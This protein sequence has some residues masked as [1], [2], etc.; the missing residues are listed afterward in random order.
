M[1]RTRAHS[2]STAGFVRIVGGIHCSRVLRNYFFSFRSRKQKNIIHQP[3]RCEKCIQSSAACNLAILV[4][5]DAP[6]LWKLSPILLWSFF[7]FMQLYG[8][9]HSWY[10]HT[11]AHNIY[12]ILCR[13]AKQCQSSQRQG[14]HT[15]QHYAG[16]R[17]TGTGP[18]NF[19]FPRSNG[20]GSTSSKHCT[21]HELYLVGSSHNQS[22]Y[23]SSG[24]NSGSSPS[25]WKLAPTHRSTAHAMHRQENGSKMMKKK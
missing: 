7:H 22:G 14:I 2:C 12:Y 4:V 21:R 24:F 8:P 19:F 15:R 6:H 20:W 5:L 23:S 10:T 11:H 3:L 16:S 1:L 25:V 17:Q 9:V 18:P 13:R